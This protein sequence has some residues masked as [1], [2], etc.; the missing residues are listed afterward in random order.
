M[1]KKFMINIKNEVQSTVRDI[2]LEE[3]ANTIKSIKT[4]QKEMLKIL[5]K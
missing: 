1:I 4:N 5:I 2:I 3:R